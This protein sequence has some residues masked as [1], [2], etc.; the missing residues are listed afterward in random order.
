[1]QKQPQHVRSYLIKSGFDHGLYGEVS[2][3]FVYQL[4]LYLL[5]KD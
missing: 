1:M 4:L 5:N 3:M 2:V